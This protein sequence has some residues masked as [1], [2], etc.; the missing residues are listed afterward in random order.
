M[1]RLDRRLE[2][3][4][5]LR[6]ILGSSNVYFEPPTSLR[7][8]YPCIRYSRSRIDTRNADNRVY[9]GRQCYEIIAIYKDA[10]SDLADKILFNDED[11]ILSHDR[12]YVADELHHDLFTTTF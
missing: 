12:H 1:T 8:K 5:K 7:M 6:S 2:L 4:A 11:L 3:D 10:D 9:L